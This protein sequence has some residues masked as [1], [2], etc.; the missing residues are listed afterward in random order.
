M[1]KVYK[2]D[3]LEEEDFTF[4]CMSM[5]SLR[6]LAKSQI[7]DAIQVVEKKK[8]TKK[9]V[10]ELESALSAH[11]EKEEYV[12]ALYDMIA[13]LHKVGYDKTLR[14]AKEKKG[15]WD[16]GVFKEVEDSER[17]LVLNMLAP[18]DVDEGI[19][20]CPQCKGKKTMHYSRQ[21]RSADEPATTFITCANKYCQYQ[22]KLN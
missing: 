18:V 16:S 19:Y 17:R 13:S 6:A 5:T 7:T 4:T 22:W 9:K 21:V 8:P 12:Q 14:D 11:K 2:M 15:G 20:Q 3:L 1:D 10:D